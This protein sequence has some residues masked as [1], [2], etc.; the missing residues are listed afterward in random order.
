M[1]DEVT[2]DRLEKERSAQWVE[3][4]V[5][6]EEHTTITD[7]LMKWTDVIEEVL[8]VQN[9]LPKDI[10]ITDEQDAKQWSTFKQN[11]HV[12]SSRDEGVYVN[13]IFPQ[14]AHE[15]I[16]TDIPNVGKDKLV[17]YEITMDIRVFYDPLDSGKIKNHMKGG[18]LL[19]NRLSFND[20]PKDATKQYL[21]VRRINAI[22]RAANRKKN[23]IP[24]DI[25]KASETWNEIWFDHEKIQKMIQKPVDKI[26][27]G[28]FG[29][30][31]DWVRPTTITTIT[32]PTI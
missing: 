20:D 25:A 23:V 12:Y 19:P 22:K 1:L 11:F 18:P 28:L 27:P 29:V 3:D 14:A 7:L 31:I 17:K 15:T 2:M 30:N 24:S 9:S 10:V 13:K 4:S 21:A 32:N 8:R 5:G 26:E 6:Q 16:E